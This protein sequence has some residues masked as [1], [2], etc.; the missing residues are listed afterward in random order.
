MGILQQLPTRAQLTDILG[1]VLG[2]R[3]SGTGVA[4]VLDLLDRLDTSKIGASLSVKLDGSLSFTASA[5]LANGTGNVVG[6]F[7]EALGALPDA[8]TLVAPLGTKLKSLQDLS[9]ESLSQQLLGGLEGLQQIESLFPPELR[10]LISGAS[11]AIGRIKGELI[12][13]AFAEIREWSASTD[14]LRGEIQK[15]VS[16][17]PGGL[18]DRLLEYLRQKI[19]DLVKAIVPGEMPG[20][21]MATGLHAAIS[22]EQISGINASAKALIEAMNFSRMEFE[23][24]DVTHLSHLDSLRVRLDQFAEAL[25]R[26]TGTLSGILD[27]PLATAEGLSHALE[28]L[29]EEFLSLEIVDVGNIRDKFAEALGKIE[30]A[31]RGIDLGIVREKIEE[32]FGKINGALDQF[33]PGELTTNLQGVQGQL[34]SVLDSLD[35]ALLQAVAS[36]RNVFAQIKD[37]LKTAAETFGE[38]DAAG[39]FRFHAQKQI[40]EFLGTVKQSLQNIRPLL[41]DFKST[42]GETLGQ[43]SDALS[44]VKDQIENVKAQLTGMLQGVNEQLAG[45]DAG[46]MIE[47]ARQKLQDMF[48]NLDGFSFDP[49]VDPVVAQINEMAAS[50]SEIDVSSLNEY[51]IGALE[52]SVE[53]VFAIDFSTQITDALMVEFD[54]LLEIPKRSLVEIETRLETVIQRFGEL[55]PEALLKPLDEV[56]KPV[57]EHLNALNLDNLLKPLDEWY[58][59]AEQGLDSVSPAALLKPLIDVHAKLNGAFDSVSP[60]E[61]VRPLREAMD[62]VKQQV[63]KLDVTG[64]G[65]QLSGAIGR[66]TAGLD[67]VAPDQLLSPVVQTFDKI[68]AALDEFNPGALLKPLDDIFG[69]LAEPLED[70]TADHAKLISDAFS[71]LRQIV[72]AFDPQHLFKVVREKATS[73]NERLGQLNPANLLVSLKGPFDSMRVS[74]QAK[75]GG[76]EVSATASVEAL[77]PM[78]HAAIS[79]AMSQLQKIESQLQALSNAQP[80]EALVRRY[81]EQLRVNV[82]ALVPV[83]AKENISPD[84]IRRAFQLLNPL[85][86]GDEINQ[87]Y[88]ALKQKLASVHPR[89]VQE[90]LAGSFEKVKAM[91]SVL[92]PSAIVAQVQGMVDGLAKSLDAV[93]LR[94]ISDELTDISGDVKAVISALDPRPII[95]GLQGSVDEAKTLVAALRP[96]ELLAEL[97]EPLELAKGIVAEFDPTQ[98]TTGLQTTFEG[99][100]KVLASI[101]IGVLLEPLSARLQQLRDELE[102]ALRRTEAAFNAMLAAI[103]V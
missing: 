20:L 65:E 85:A 23:R 88:D 26:V 87:I 70:L 46:G 64:L 74:F 41:D 103:P 42:I 78:R 34:Q 49:V 12:S 56:F 45:L 1:P 95:D 57:A 47:S 80:P 30:A 102:E 76:A 40:E 7:Q 94:V 2:Q 67:R 48:R 11:D 69:A 44:G 10:E 91:T 99:I 28:R 9:G 14:V 13:G 59:R 96:S 92:D 97:K 50:L 86:L 75:G 22:S 8:A 21:S 32:V 53:V 71:V 98:F 61:L 60:A 36:V 5:D 58:A 101:D 17:G 81:N 19:A 27:R 35:G 39:R 16:D 89:I 90:G 31:I 54:K 66:V 62:G 72:D 93:D 25:S 3:G 52:V 6:Q 18:V 79:Q 24:G 43:V 51:T 73:A 83:W 82:E 29:F 84:S 100:Q 55:G 15:L 68:V 38:F 4:G 77:N 63:H 37:A 33:N